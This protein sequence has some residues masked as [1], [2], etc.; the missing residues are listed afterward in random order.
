MKP[1]QKKT[2]RSPQIVE[3]FRDE[4]DYS[5]SFS[6]VD[7]NPNDE[8]FV[9]ATPTPQKSLKRKLFSPKEKQNKNRA[10]KDEKNKEKG[11][12]QRSVQDSK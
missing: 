3:K 5:D 12:D 8:D 11:S 10:K 2:G 7:D 1:L 4:D 9:P 6:E